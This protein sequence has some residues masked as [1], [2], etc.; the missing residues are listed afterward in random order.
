MRPDGERFA[1]LKIQNYGGGLP[2][3]ESLERIRPDSFPRTPECRR[4][5]ECVRGETVLRNGSLH[6][7]YCDWCGLKMACNCFLCETLNHVPVL[8]PKCQVTEIANE[9]F[10]NKGTGEA[11][12]KLVADKRSERDEGRR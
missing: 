5:W 4:T 7:V 9:M 8:C 6:R 12:K 1:F 2:R 3:T 10:G 11:G